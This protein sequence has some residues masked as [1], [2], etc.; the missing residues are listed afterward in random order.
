[1][2]DTMREHFLLEIWPEVVERLGLD[3][4]AEPTEEEY[5]SWLGIEIDEAELYYLEERDEEQGT[6]CESG[7]GS[8][9]A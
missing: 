2:T 9:G 3:P 4:N 7:T 8:N 5:L 1:M 6:E